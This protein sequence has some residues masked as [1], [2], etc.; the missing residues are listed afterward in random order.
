MAKRGYRLQASGIRGEENMS[1]RIPLANAVEAAREIL[2]DVRKEPY[3]EESRV[4]LADWL[5]EKGFEYP[6]S[7]L[8]K[9][10]DDSGTEMLVVL[11]SL[12]SL[13][14]DK[15]DVPGRCLGRYQAVLGLPE[16]LI[17]PGITRSIELTTMVS[18]R[19]RRMVLPD[20]VARVV[21]VPDG[22]IGIQSLFCSE[23]P[24]PGIMFSMSA[25]ELF[26]CSVFPGQ[27]IILVFRNHTEQDIVVSGCLL[28]VNS[29]DRFPAGDS[30]DPGF[31]IPP[32]RT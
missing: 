10:P 16:T 27:R 32:S 21:S 25:P 5:E 3:D 8:R 7:V 12:R 2:A 31:L 17:G 30:I 19:L 29:S 14:G 4:V 15:K 13:F 24:V 20:T 1:K 23:Q 28:G 11:S 9:D 22:R 26:D 18:C 6:A